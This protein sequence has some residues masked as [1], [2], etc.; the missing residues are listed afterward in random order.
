MKNELSWIPSA[1]G[2]EAI[3]AET[4]GMGPAITR[5][6][7]HNFDFERITENCGCFILARFFVQSFRNRIKSRAIEAISNPVMLFLR[8]ALENTQRWYLVYPNRCTLH[9][10]SRSL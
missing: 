5:R 1:S 3:E 10:I 4:G 2:S 6:P 9:F 8:R 7:M